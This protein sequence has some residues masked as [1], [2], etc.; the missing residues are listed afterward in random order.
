MQG[1][2]EEL[3]GRAV[4]P[5]ARGRDHDDPVGQLPD[6]LREQRRLAD[7][8]AGGPQGQGQG[9]EH[10]EGVVDRAAS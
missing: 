6:R 8:R 7:R 4:V 10:V 9:R 5:V 3:P 1:R 2:G